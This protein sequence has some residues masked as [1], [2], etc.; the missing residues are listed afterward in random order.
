VC[1]GHGQAI[2]RRRTPWQGGH[3]RLAPTRT[4]RRPRQE[5]RD[6]R[7]GNAGRVRHVSSSSSTTSVEVKSCVSKVVFPNQTTLGTGGT[8]DTLRLAF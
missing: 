6:V 5:G 3:A 8:D 1:A 7:R 4:R 2:S